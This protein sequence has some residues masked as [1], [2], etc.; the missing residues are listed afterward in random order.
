MIQQIFGMVS[1]YHS[2]VTPFQMSMESPLFLV[3]LSNFDVTND[4]V[5]AGVIIISHE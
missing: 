2:S 1:S 5:D 4:N 3:L